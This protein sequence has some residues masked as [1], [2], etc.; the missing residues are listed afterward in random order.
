MQKTLYAHTTEEL[1]R[2]YIFLFRV[3]SEADTHLKENAPNDR[4]PYNEN[5][6]HHRIYCESERAWRE[7]RQIDKRFPNLFRWY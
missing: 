7:M 4:P 5:P 3:V 1:R 2:R 6:L